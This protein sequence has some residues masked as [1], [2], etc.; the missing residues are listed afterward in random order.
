MV[1]DSIEVFPDRDNVTT[2]MESGAYEQSVCGLRQDG[3]C[4]HTVVMRGGSGLRQLGLPSGQR[5]RVFTLDQKL[6][7]ALLSQWPEGALKR[8]CRRVQEKS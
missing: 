7:V 8:N 6:A 4:T 5:H 2:T 1:L 3:Q